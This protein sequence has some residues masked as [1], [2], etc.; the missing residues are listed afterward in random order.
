MSAETFVD[1]PHTPEGLNAY[2]HKIAPIVDMVIGELLTPDDNVY[3]K[4]YNPR[5]KSFNPAGKGM[6]RRT[7]QL[8]HGRTNPRFSTDWEIWKRG[9]G[10]QQWTQK[11]VGRPS[12]SDYWMYA[13]HMDKNTHFYNL[14]TI[15]AESLD[16]PMQLEADMLYLEDVRRD[17]YAEYFR[18]MH[19]VTAGRHWMP[20]KDAS[21][22]FHFDYRIG[23]GSFAAP[24]RFGT[25]F[26]GCM[27]DVDNI[28]VSPDAVDAITKVAEFTP[29]C[30]RKIQQVTASHQR[31]G[32]YKKVNLIV[33]D[34]APQDIFSADD[35]LIE[36][37]KRRSLGG[38]VDN[39]LLWNTLDMTKKLG[40]L[41]TFDIDRRILRYKD[42]GETNDAGEF[43]LDRVDQFLDVNT[44]SGDMGVRSEENPDW[45]N[46]LVAAFELYVVDSGPIFTPM[47]A[48]WPDSLGNG[49]SF[50][51]RPSARWNWY[52]VQDNGVNL[53][54]DWGFFNMQDDMMA[55]RDMGWQTAGVILVRR[56]TEDLGIEGVS[57]SLISAQYENQDSERDC[58]T[59]QPVCNPTCPPTQPG[60]GY[61]Y[62]Q[63]S[64]SCPSCF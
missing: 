3:N 47:R 7:I 49:M 19:L 20:W 28:F 38:D 37:L 1:V 23:A 64:P 25:V 44:G 60:F 55:K 45:E 36:T 63:T 9:C 21:N 54:N 46:P 8:E 12:T 51:Q 26:D 27:Q 14:K 16:L 34:T 17:T 59:V 42:S 24:W 53:R 52:N 50:P 61:S 18:A 30:A 33:S 11:E 57:A 5:V 41:L 32:A 39:T 6:Q 13:L 48:A 22:N 40:D 35:V 29:K 43:R 62:S 15:L 10:P 2:Y 31:S 4:M 58:A 56:K